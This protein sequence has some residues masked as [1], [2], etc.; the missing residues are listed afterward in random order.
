MPTLTVGAHLSPREV[1]STVLSH[2]PPS[3]HLLLTNSP[4]A[5]LTIEKN[6]SLERRSD[7]S[8]PVQLQNP[9]PTHYGAG[10]VEEEGTNGKQCV[11]VS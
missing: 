6:H 4:I 3:S 8:N 5:M 10:K 11:G 1:P 2:L 9:F 7:L